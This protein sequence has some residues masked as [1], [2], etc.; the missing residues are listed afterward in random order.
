MFTPM[1]RILLSSK[2]FPE[3]K[4]IG[5]GT[6]LISIINTVKNFLPEHVWFGA[7]VEAVGKDASKIE[8]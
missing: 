5:L 7:D 6:Q 3:D 2:C 4:V 8:Y 1:H